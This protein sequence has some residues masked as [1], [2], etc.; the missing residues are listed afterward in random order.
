[1]GNGAGLSF[2]ALFFILFCL[3]MF[4]IIGS[5][6]ILIVHA[7]NCDTKDSNYDEVNYE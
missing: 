4:F 3:F 7:G 1:M 5:I 6:F 2:E